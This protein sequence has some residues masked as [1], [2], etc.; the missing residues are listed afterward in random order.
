MP[1]RRLI[2]LAVSLVLATAATAGVAVAANPG[3]RV[4]AD[5]TTALGPVEF[6][7]E[8]GPDGE[9]SGYFVGDVT[10]GGEMSLAHAE[11]P[12]TC[13]TVEGDRAAFVYRVTDAGAAPTAEPQGI[14]VSMQDGGDDG[15]D[16]I[17]FAGPGPIADLGVCPVG[18]APL[19]F[20]GDMEVSAG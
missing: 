5:G 12:P 11:G 4:S 3:D 15:P 7:V 10:L 16:R 1:V 2:V 20:T 18:P 8:A 14:Y 17:G 9:L 6:L 13:L 19:E